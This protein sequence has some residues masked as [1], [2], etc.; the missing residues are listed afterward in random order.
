MSISPMTGIDSDA[1]NVVNMMDQALETVISAYQSYSVPLPER[2]YWTVGQVAVDCE[3]LTIAL[4]QL[5][6]GTPGD[7][8]TSP[9]RCHVP[10]SATFLITVARQIPVV[11]QNGRPPTA[12]KITDAAKISA[13]DAWVLSQSINGFDQWDESGFGLGVIATVDIPPPEGGYQTVNMT[14][15]MAVP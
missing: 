5:Y 10:R 11:G 8:A 2:Q 14:V 3:Q 6:L 13:V 7:Q 12:D 15:I 1:L 9:Q 4:L